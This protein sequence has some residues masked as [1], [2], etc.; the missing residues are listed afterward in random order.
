[1]RVTATVPRPS[2]ARV[3]SILRQAGFAKATRYKPFGRDQDG[4]EVRN[5]GNEYTC[6]EY[7]HIDVFDSRQ[8][9]KRLEDYAKAL[10]DAGYEVKVRSF[11]LEVKRGS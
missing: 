3:S 4:Y 8:Y 11:S 10:R 5:P 2:A 7:D 9:G 6:D 1:M